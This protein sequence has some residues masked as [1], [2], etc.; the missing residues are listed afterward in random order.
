MSVVCAIA[1]AGVTFY[2][3]DTVSVTDAGRLLDTGSKWTATDGVWAFGHVGE[4]R[5]S[6]LIT[7]HART[8]FDGMGDAWAFPGRLR[9]VYEAAGLRPSHGRDGNDACPSW[10]NSG[11][12]IR[13]GEVYDVDAALSVV[14]IPVGMLYAR[15][16][17]GD[18]AMAAAWGF[19]RATPSAMPENVVLAALAGAA[20]H[21]ALIRGVW[22][23]R[24]AAP[25]GTAKTAEG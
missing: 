20:A 11:L 18:L 19:R 4:S 3:S 1:V 10:G 2:G 9:T 23:A 17:A 6:D 7:T 8:L 16:S 13:A 25:A 24:L 15:G 12:L 21:N 5:A 22:Q 14:R